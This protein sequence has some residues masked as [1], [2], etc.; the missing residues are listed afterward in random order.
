[1]KVIIAA[2]AIQLTFGLKRYIFQFFRR[3]IIQPEQYRIPELNE[4]LLGHVDK[5]R[6]TITLSW[7]N[8]EYGF[9]IPND[10]H[11]VALHELA[12]VILFEN[13]LRSRLNE[14]FA[15]PHWEHWLEKAEPQFIHNQNRKN[16]LLKEYAD[17]NLMEMFSVSV[18]TFFEQ[19]QRFKNTLPELYS[20]LVQLLQQDPTNP[21]NP[22]FTP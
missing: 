19:S 14:F 4:K 5:N 2:A 12:H 21:G 15:R 7:A 13:S 9:L 17:N 10:A 11:N 18:E 22:R 6:K 20:A 16:V 3:I 8:T 1:M